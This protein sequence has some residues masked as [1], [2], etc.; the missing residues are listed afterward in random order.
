[1]ERNFIWNDPMRGFLIIHLIFMCN[2]A[3]G[4]NWH[5]DHASFVTFSKSQKLKAVDCRAKTKF[6]KSYLALEP[7]IFEIF[8][9]NKD[10]II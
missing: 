4:S 10:C 2:T 6:A 8:E 3:M 7:L 9:M 5:V 1:M